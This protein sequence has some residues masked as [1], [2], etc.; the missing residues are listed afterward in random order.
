MATVFQAEIIAITTDCQ[1]LKQRRK[2]VILIRCDSQ[3]AI[4]AVLATNISSKI[5]L[6]CRNAINTL[7]EV[8]DETIS[9]IKA[10]VEHPG[11][12]LA[13]KQAKAGAI[14]R[15][16]PGPW[17]WHSHPEPISFFK[18]NLKHKINQQWQKRWSANPAICW[19]SKCFIQNIEHV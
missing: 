15:Q 3:A 7:G 1:L 9:W 10:H 6:D 17:H 12:E 4:Q 19:Q 11:N 2:Q 5:V 18:L 16:G 8:N 14:P 13:D